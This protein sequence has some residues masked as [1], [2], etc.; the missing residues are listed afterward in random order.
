LKQPRHGPKIDWSDYVLPDQGQNTETAGARWLLIQEIS[1]VFPGFFEE[2]RDRVYP[3]F[4]HLMESRPDYWEP[5]WT[6][7]TWQLQPDPDRQLASVLSDW[8]RRFHAEEPWILDGA[9]RTL[10]LWHRDPELR[11]YLDIGGFRYVCCAD[12]LS[13]EEDREFTFTHAGWDPQFQRLEGF[14]HSLKKE[15]QTQLDAYEQRLSSLMELG[16]AV[17]ARKR[18]NRVHISWFVLYQ[19]GGMSSVKILHK[20]PDLKGDESTILKGV[21]ATAHLLQWENVRK[22]RD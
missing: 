15:F 18:Y 7:A 4:A 13:S 10:W 2:L 21:K 16:G 12:T 19:L 5:A 17:R 1:L 6:F 14:R 20:H 11:E 3:T 8:A 9:L 22:A